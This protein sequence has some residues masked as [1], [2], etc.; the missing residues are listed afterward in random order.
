MDEIQR[1]I[2]SVK[3]RRCVLRLAYCFISN[4]F[5]WN[6]LEFFELHEDI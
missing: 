2:I 1:S 5:K 6:D 3:E 4:Q